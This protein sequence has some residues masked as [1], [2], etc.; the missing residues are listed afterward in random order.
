M[1]K[2][3]TRST[4]RKIEREAPGD[5]GELA[6][7]TF[8]NKALLFTLLRG[9]TAE[10]LQKNITNA[11]TW[12]IV[13]T[14]FITRLS[15]G[16]NKFRYRMEVKHCIRGNGE[17]LRNFLHRIKRTVD[18]GW[19]DYLNGIEAAQHNAE[20]EDQGRQRRQRYNGYSLKGLRPR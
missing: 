17:N 4:C 19:P 11:T 15:D 1:L 13:Q 16:R 18:K 12:E 7:Y 3:R 2:N 5:P 6:N 20:R 8:R 10:M 9:P 14:N